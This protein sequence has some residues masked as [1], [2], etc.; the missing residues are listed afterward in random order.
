M[1]DA[2]AVELATVLVAVVAEQDDHTLDGCAQVDEDENGVKC[3]QGQESV[4]HR[5]YNDVL[6]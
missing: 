3:D 2:I 5:R 6:N 4:P 1:L